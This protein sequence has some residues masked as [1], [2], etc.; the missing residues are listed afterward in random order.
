[1]PA[2]AAPGATDRSPAP[3]PW[4]LRWWQPA[5]AAAASLTL[6]LAFTTGATQQALNTKNEQVERLTP[7]ATQVAQVVPMM[8]SAR[9]TAVPLRPAAAPSA[10]E[11]RLVVDNQDG[12]ALLLVRQLPPLPQNR[13]YQV[14]VAPSH[15]QRPMPAGVFRVDQ[16][17]IGLLSLSLPVSLDQ[18]RRLMV[19]IEPEEGS[20]EPT[21][22]PVLDAAL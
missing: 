17:G 18:L 13:A 14:W 3:P 8:F 2:V 12:K 1:L 6:V 16:D 10:P 4:R 22:Q 7:K 19:T 5:L 21:G 20:V 15:E 11:G 9:A